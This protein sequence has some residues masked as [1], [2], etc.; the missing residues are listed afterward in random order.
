MERFFPVTWAATI[1]STASRSGKAAGAARTGSMSPTDL[2]IC[3]PMIIRTTT[4]I[5]KTAMMTR[6]PTMITQ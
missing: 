2:P 4:M 5:W 1:L 6:R 3:I